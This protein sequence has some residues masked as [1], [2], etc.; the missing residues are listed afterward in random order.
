[1]PSQWGGGRLFDA[2]TVF[3]YENG[4]NSGTES[5]K[6]VPKVGNE[7]SLRGLRTGCSP[8]LGSCG[9]IG[10]F[11]QK[12]SFGAQKKAHFLTLTML[13]P[14]PGK[15]FKKKSCLFPNKYQ[16]L[17]KL[18]VF[19][20]IKPIFGQKKH[21][22]AEPKNGCFSVI[23]AQTRSVVI[24]GH[25]LMSRTVPP[26]FVENGPKLRVLIPLKWEWPKTAKN[27]GE[28]RKMTYS[29]ETEIFWGGQNGKVDEKPNYHTIN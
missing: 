14:L 12:P 26:S 29:S 2:S 3:F 19:F 23:P 18:L 11:G 13:W 5:Q 10:F 24:L 27:R 9:K 16:S 21:F 20:F 1:M 4:C 25:F 17:K 8:N 22:S 15:L 7:R 28:P 6:I